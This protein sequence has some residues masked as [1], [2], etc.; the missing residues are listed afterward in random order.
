MRRTNYT[1]PSKIVIRK[2]PIRKLFLF[3]FS[4]KIKYEK[5]IR[6]IIQISNFH[7]YISYNN[8]CKLNSLSLTI[9]IQ[10]NRQCNC[11]FSMNNPT[12]CFHLY[13]SHDHID[14]FSIFLRNE[15]KSVKKKRKKSY[16]LQ[17][18]WCSGSSTKI[19]PRYRNPRHAECDQKWRGDIRRN[20]DDNNRF[21]MRALCPHIG[22]L[23]PYSVQTYENTPDDVCRDSGSCLPLRSKNC[24]TFR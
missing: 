4:I 12:I 10:V 21:N 13:S 14:R 6:S 24:Q 8:L 2:I 3:Y 9:I 18:F 22:S 15:I 23:V 16:L 20:R 19:I 17:R 1:I 11:K 7:F 5:L